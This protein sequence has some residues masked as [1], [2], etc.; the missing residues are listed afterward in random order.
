[1][2]SHW[3]AKKTARNATPLSAD[4]S[5]SRP[6][7]KRRSST[8][9]AAAGATSSNGNGAGTMCVSGLKTGAS[10]GVAG[11]SWRVQPMTREI[12][13]YAAAAA[14]AGHR[15]RAARPAATRTSGKTPPANW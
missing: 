12:A 9:M 10:L 3:T 6:G 11:K 5:Q 1:M 14:V 8:S 2:N 15:R 7:P 4:S 13:M